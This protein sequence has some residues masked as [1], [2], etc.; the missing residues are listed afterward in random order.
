MGLLEQ[1]DWGRSFQTAAPLHAAWV[2]KGKQLDLSPAPFSCV[3]VGDKSSFAAV[4]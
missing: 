4:R 2:S 1:E 3:Q